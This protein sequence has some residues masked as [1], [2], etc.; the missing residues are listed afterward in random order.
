MEIWALIPVKSLLQSKRR[1]AH[2]LAAEQ[3]AE[4]IT[5]LLRRELDVLSR[6]PA[7]RQV[8]VISSDPQVWKIARRQ[9]VLVEEEAYSPGLNA[10]VTRGMERAAGHG[11][12]AVLIL[13]VDL[14][15][16]DVAD[17]EMMVGSGWKGAMPHTL[18]PAVAGYEGEYGTLPERAN[19]CAMSICADAEGDG[20]NALFLDPARDF[21]FHFGPGSFQKHLQ[22]AQ[23]RGRHVH[24]ISAPGMKFDIDSESDWV[25]YQRSPIGC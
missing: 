19:V 22:E 12:H 14:P 5:S 7:L 11:A 8:L 24:I 6:V 20:T 9:G 16:V 4:L 25:A 3:R 10:A 1:L 23:K 15:Y 21:T 2:V 13:P 17:V 18:G